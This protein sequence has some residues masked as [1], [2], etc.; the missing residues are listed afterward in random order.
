MKEEIFINLEREIFRGNVLDIGARN[1][2]IIYNV[3]KKYNDDISLEY[4][5][6][7]KDKENIKDDYYDNCILLFSFRNVYFKR[8][9]TK[10][11]KEIYKY[12]KTGGCLYIWDI[13]KNYGKTFNGK[14]KI[15]VPN[16]KLKKLSIKDINIFKDNSK[17]TILS[18]LKP[19]FK[20]EDLK[21]SDGI[22]Y[23]KAKKLKNDK[24][25]QDEETRKEEKN[26]SSV[27]SG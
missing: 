20:I 25:L 19:Y 12:M 14:L 5:N 3:Y 9:K 23:I 10:L 21:N 6:G 13:D 27:S 2:G 1:Y 22:Y 7:E 15:L 4:I 18:I 24:K 26:E 17:K 8:T 16:G 11:V